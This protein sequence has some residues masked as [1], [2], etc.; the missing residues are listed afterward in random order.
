LGVNHREPP[1]GLSDVLQGSAHFDDAVFK[2]QELNLYLLPA[3]RPVN[4]PADLL[5]KPEFENLLREISQRFD[6]IIIDSPPILALA[7]AR[8]M[9]PFSDAMLM[10]V[11]A[12]KTPTNLVRDSIQRIGRDRICGV[13]LNGARHSKSAYYYG[14]YYKQILPDEKTTSRN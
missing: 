10:V 4:N 3:G 12:E 1:I 8:V 5:S 13:V 2:C 6:W 14:Q 7:D 11:R 9:A